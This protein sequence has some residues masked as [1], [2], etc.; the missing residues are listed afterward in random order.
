MKLF[1]IQFMTYDS[2]H[3]YMGGSNNYW[4]GNLR[5][6]TENLESLLKILDDP[7]A[8]VKDYH[9]NSYLVNDLYINRHSIKEI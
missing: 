8:I 1:D 9:G 7:E 3:N 5:I 4:F 2:Y 6:R